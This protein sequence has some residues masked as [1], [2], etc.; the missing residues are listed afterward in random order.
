MTLHQAC[1]T[2]KDP[3]F[4]P[5]PSSAPK[6]IGYTVLR[7]GQ[8]LA[9]EVCILVP[10]LNSFKSAVFDP[11]SKRLE[12]DVGGA[13]IALTDIPL[14]VSILLTKTPKNVLLMSV[15][16]LS[17]VRLSVRVCDIQH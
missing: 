11:A 12:V 6:A 2:T 8:G 9:S 10:H 4:L 17:R 3:F 7:S 13:R 14:D 15:D 16:T 1:S 5:L